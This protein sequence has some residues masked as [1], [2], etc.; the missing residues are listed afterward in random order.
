MTT[1]MSFIAASLI[2]TSH[3]YQGPALIT[4]PT[5]LT[6]RI[7]QLV[8]QSGPMTASEICE[9][10]SLP[11]PALVG[12]LLKTDLHRGRVVFADGSYVWNISY[13]AELQGDLDDAKRLLERHGFVVMKGGAA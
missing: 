12:A 4:R 7:R 10:L 5:T 1:P 8:Q 13:D 11:R 3:A 2:R 6:D 9:Q